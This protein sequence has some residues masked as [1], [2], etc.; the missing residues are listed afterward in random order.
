MLSSYLVIRKIIGTLG[1]LLPILVFAGHKGVLLT[2]ISHY[3]YTQ[4]AVFFIAILSAFGLFLISYK[5]YEKSATEKISD[6]VITQIGGFAALLVILLPTTCFKGN[7]GLLTNIDL[8]SG[9]FMFGHSNEIIGVIHLICAGVFLF[10]MG[11][12]SIFKFTKSENKKYN[13]FY[14]FC[15]YTV[16]ISIGLLLVEFALKKIL[17]NEDFHVTQYDVFILETVAIIAFGSS[18]LIKGKAL[19]DV[20]MVI[21][22]FSG[23][24]K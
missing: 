18:W 8:L 19:E 7:C 22:K 24:S 16:W 3:Y 4:S 9:G 23:K 13:T 5:G 14:K 11:W 17:K 15:G 2:S 12:M 10:A 1:I 6:N 21:Q 20:S